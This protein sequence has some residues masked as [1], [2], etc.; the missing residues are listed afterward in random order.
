MGS[1]SSHIHQIWTPNQVCWSRMKSMMSTIVLTVLTLSSRWLL[2]GRTLSAS[3]D[4]HWGTEHFSAPLRLTTSVVTR[5]WRQHVRTDDEVYRY[6]IDL[7]GGRRCTCRKAASRSMSDEYTYT[8]CRFP[9]VTKKSGERVSQMGLGLRGGVLFTARWIWVVHHVW[10]D[11]I[12]PDRSCRPWAL[13]MGS[14]PMWEHGQVT[15]GWVGCGLQWSA[16]II[17]VLLDQWG[18]FGPWNFIF[19]ISKFLFRFLSLIVFFDNGMIH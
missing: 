19:F 1:S 5:G 12:A 6:G 16:E 7:G 15:T 4:D 13:P 3:I 14:K 11:E 2:Y 10:T 9:C 18:S 8:I 17:L